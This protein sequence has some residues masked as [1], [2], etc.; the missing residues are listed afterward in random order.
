MVMLSPA[1]PH[2]VM[3]VAAVFPLVVFDTKAKPLLHHLGKQPPAHSQPQLRAKRLA[4]QPHAALSSAGSSFAKRH[5]SPGW[6]NQRRNR[7]K[8]TSHG[9]NETRHFLTAKA[10]QGHNRDPDASAPSTPAWLMQSSLANEPGS[11]HCG[12]VVDQDDLRVCDPE[13]IEYF[14]RLS[15]LVR[16][17]PGSADRLYKDVVF[18]GN[19]GELRLSSCRMGKGPFWTATKRAMRLIVDAQYVNTPRCCSAMELEGL[20]TDHG[21]LRSWTAEAVTGLQLQTSAQGLPFVEV[22]PGPGI[23]SEQFPCPLILQLAGDGVVVPGVGD[24]WLLVQA[25]CDQCGPSLRAVLIAPGVPQDLVSPEGVTEGAS[26][27]TVAGMIIPLVEDHLKMHPDLDPNRIYIAAQSKGVD[28][29]I[30][31]ALRAPHLF[32]MAIFAGL[33]LITD[34][35]KKALMDPEVMQGLENGRLHRIQFHIGDMDRC[36]SFDEFFSSF[37]ETFSKAMPDRIKVDLRVYTES[38]HSIW[39]AAWNTLHEVIWTGMRNF[40]DA[41][42]PLSCHGIREQP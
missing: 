17:N 24:P 27:E 2:R 16:L 38:K 32:T 5:P 18:L 14:S 22:W 30:R 4:R 12:D 21:V 42:I 9:R 19:G 34:A 33:F 3:W 29:G 40:W 39:Y 26:D 31:A 8:L 13:D 41:D 37:A 28:T 15:R 6:R 20:A 7:T 35:T 23:C 1:P 25:A 36:F 11:L 10:K